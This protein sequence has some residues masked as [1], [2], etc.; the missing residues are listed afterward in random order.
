MGENAET[1]PGK[2]AE[3]GMLYKWQRSQ[4]D[5]PI[6]WGKMP[7]LNPEY[8]QRL[9]CCSNG[10]EAKPMTQLN[11]RKCRNRTLN[12]GRDWDAAQMAMRPNR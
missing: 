2:W 7:K 5:D 11:G 12:M 4:T 9:R 3:I 1:E 10:N 6:E 8:G